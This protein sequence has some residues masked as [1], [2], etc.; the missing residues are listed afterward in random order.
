MS[1][2]MPTR[3]HRRV[4]VRVCVCALTGGTQGASKPAVPTQ[5]GESS[6]SH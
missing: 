1:T 4:C 5:R 2:C 3:E 6:A